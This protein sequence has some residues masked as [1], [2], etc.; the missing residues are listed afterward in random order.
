MKYNFRV[1]KYFHGWC[2]RFLMALLVA[3]APQLISTV[4]VDAAA[5]D[6]DPEFGSNGKI[7]TQFSNGHG[8]AHAIALQPDGK[9]IVAGFAVMSDSDFALARYNH[10]G[11]PDTTF[12]ND[13]K[14][15][16]DFVGG[17]DA[18]SAVAVQ[19]DGKI[20]AVGTATTT[21]TSRDFAIVR[22]NINGT[23]D[24]NF[25]SGGIVM[26]DFGNTLD[27]AHAILVLPDAKILVG[28]GGAGNHFTLAQYNPD[29]SPDPTFGS[30]GYVTTPF[31]GFSWINA[32]ALQPNG[33]IIAAGFANNGNNFDFAL[34]RY[35]SDGNLDLSF[36]FDGK[37]LLHFGLADDGAFDVLRQPDGKI[38][39]AGR[40]HALDILGS[41]DKYAL[42]RYLE[43]G[44]LDTTFSG[45]GV[46][47]TS[48][49]TSDEYASGVALQ[50][51]G[52]IIAGG[53][54]AGVGD[55]SS[56]FGIIRYNSDG[57][58]DQSYGTNGVAITDFFQAGDFAEDVVI[59]PDGKVIAVGRARLG[60]TDVFALARYQTDPPPPCLFCDDFQDNILAPDWTYMKPH[61]NEAGGNLV[62]SPAAK[63]AEVIAF[64]VFAGCS[65]CTVKARISTNGA[66]FN[67]VWLLAWYEDKKN[68]IE[69]LMNEETD[70]WIIKQRAGGVIVAKAK[71]S[72]VI[73]PNT[74]YK[75][76]VTFNGV[77]FTLAVDG[78]P[79]ITMPAAVA[80]NGTVGFRV[81]NAVIRA[82]SIFV[83]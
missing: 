44:T 22:Y 29:G 41:S 73:V 12:S 33:K 19:P 37:A 28:G 14:V 26:T 59:Q 54:T 60:N 61:W 74:F 4:D 38:V 52:K 36:S 43:D 63:K 39:V 69:V 50:P 24:N 57:S 6:P 20:I 42:A 18:A 64:P 81:K 5:G 13:G 17:P 79:L 80:P 7:I 71:A 51:D 55:S 53:S 67:K 3:S 66:L 45:D 2:G 49:G 30:N 68:N 56:N 76:Q 58:A 72:A 9:I 77:N 62:G 32:L 21:T 31:A 35:E 47:T 25:G 15:T 23:L 46:L 70:K 65:V 16:K 82:D 48:F 34:A 1:P 27:G 75:V 83:N 10:D 8:S 40:A 78:T 11:S